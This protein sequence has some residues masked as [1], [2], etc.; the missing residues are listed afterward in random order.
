M[1]ATKFL[2]LFRNPTA[3]APSKPAS[4]E[5]MQAMYLA[6]NKWKEKFDKELI[7]GFGLKPTSTMVKAG[8]VTDGPFVE[9]KEI[10]ASFCTVSATSMARAVEIAKECPINNTPGGSIEIREI[11]EY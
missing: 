9:S 5:Q 1:S 7:P 2:F 11:A 3:G 6:W 10:I 4:P 8:S